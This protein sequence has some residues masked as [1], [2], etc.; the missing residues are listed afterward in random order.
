MTLVSWRWLQVTLKFLKQYSSL[1]SVIQEALS[2]YREG[3]SSKAFPSPLHTPYRIDDEQTT[4]FLVAFQ[5]RG[6]HGAADATQA[7][8]VHDVASSDPPIKTPVD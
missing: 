7:T 8:A 2:Q 4:A 5:K 6:L 1:G 3:V